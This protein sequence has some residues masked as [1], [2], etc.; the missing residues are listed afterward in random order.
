MSVF[1]ISCNNKNVGILKEKKKY[2]RKI[3]ASSFITKIKMKKRNMNPVSSDPAT[4]VSR[5]EPLHN[6]A[7]TVLRHVY[8]ILN[9]FDI[10][11]IRC[12]FYSH[13]CCQCLKF[14]RI[15]YS[16]KYE[17]NLNVSS[18]IQSK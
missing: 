9:L 11:F 7:T 18:L 5:V 1:E 12:K 4:I 17:L 14:L 3:L 13:G 16:N 6:L 15:T 2:P 8:K 10:L